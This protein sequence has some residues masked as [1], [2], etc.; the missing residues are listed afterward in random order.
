MKTWTRTIL[1]GVLLALSGCIVSLH[2]LY[3]EEDVIFKPAL[4]GTWIKGKERDRG[5]ETWEFKQ[6]PKNNSYSLEHI[7][8][9]GEKGK[10]TVHLFRVGDLLFLDLEIHHRVGG[11]QN[12]MVS[13][14]MGVITHSVMLVERIAPTPRI[15]YLDAELLQQMAKAHSDVPSFVEAQCMKCSAVVT[16]STKEMQ[17]FLVRYAKTESASIFAEP[18]ELRR[19]EMHE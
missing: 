14:H 11:A 19:K 8:E 3:T 6:G 16:A 5:E 15:A 10:F 2:P 1:I 4:L 9:R 18:F 13:D 12:D 7:D 17:R